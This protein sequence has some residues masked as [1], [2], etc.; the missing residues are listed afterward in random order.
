MSFSYDV[1]KELCSGI[2]DKDKQYACL[3]GMLMFCK[4]FSFEQIT[5]QTEHELS[6]KLFE[7]LANHFTAAEVVLCNETSKRNGTVVYTLTIS[8]I[9]A[10]KSLTSLY[11]ISAPKELHRIKQ[12]F[13]ETISI[14]DFLAGVFLSCGSVIDPNKEYHLE[15]VAPYYNLSQDLLN[16]LEKITL[17]LNTPNVRVFM[18]Y[19]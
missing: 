17:Q 8:D 19:I 18:F 1:K 15:F 10:C 6:A 16:I 7:A 9:N 3:Y 14:P 2:T 13:L 5:L 11:H 4:Q 12:E